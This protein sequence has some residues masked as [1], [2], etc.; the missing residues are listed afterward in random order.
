MAAALSSL[1]AACSTPVTQPPGPP[2]TTPVLNGD[3]FIAADGTRLAIQSWLPEG[4]DPTAVLI[5]LHGFN[6]YS[7]FFSDPGRYFKDRGMAAY[8]F[9]QRGFGTTPVRGIWPGTDGLVDDLQT[10]V[11]LV[12]QRHPGRPLYVIG[13]SMGG[14]VA[15]VAASRPEPLAID[16]MI[17]AAPAVWGRQTMA[18]AQTAVLWLSAHI[19]PGV[20]MTG[21]SL[22]IKP[23]DNIEML[24]RLSR[25]PLVIKATRI[26]AM[27]GLTNLMDA[28]LAAAAAL[29]VPSFILYGEKDEIIP[30][31]PTDLMLA[32]LP[33]G[34]G[35][36][37]VRF[38]KD[39]YHMLLR[40]LQAETVWADIAGWIDGRSGLAAR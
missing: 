8:A 32:R 2:V 37:T 7:N 6:D 11:R 17:L 31:Q 1:L 33:G 22:K 3:H 16:G 30:R 9:D 29:Q 14:A 18:W 21:Q 35:R 19:M 10:M 27:Y 34:P 5:A 24:R 23:S 15:M 20:R 13:E 12:R 38:Y 28:A 36:H 39:G 4:A 40:D 25:D 26:D